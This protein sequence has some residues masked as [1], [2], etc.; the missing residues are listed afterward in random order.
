MAA[1][2]S[3]EQAPPLD[4]TFRFFLTAPWFGAAA[5]LLLAWS[6]PAALASRWLPQAMAL[7][8]LL[9]AGFLLQ[10]MCG[11]LM[12]VV[13]V[14]AGANIARPRLVATVVHGA[15]TLGAAALTV[16]FLAG[17]ADWMAFAQIALGAGITVFV[18]AVVAAL[19]NAAASPM[20]P[21]LR[22]ALAALAVTALLG[23][24]L[25]QALSGRPGLPPGLSF[26]GVVDVHAS[27]GLGAWA[28]VLL[29]GVSFVVVPMF[30]LTPPYPAWLQRA[31]A[32]GLLGLLAL[33]AVAVLCGAG[34]AARALGAA[35]LLL[36]AVFALATLHLQ[37]RSR[38][39]R[40]DATRLFFRAAMASLLAAVALL[41]APAAGLRSLAGPGAEVA[42]G[43]LLLC[44]VLVSAVCG[45]LYKIVPFICWLKRP[46]GPARPGRESLIT[47]PAMRMQARLHFVSLALL[48]AS[49]AFP[50]A[51]RAAGLAFAASCALLGA[52]LVRATARALRA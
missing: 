10:A 11:A 50:A 52:N 7:V 47:E 28:L 14:M 3:F 34:L 21:A 12:Q 30:Q 16:A 27:A 23:I 35:A 29:A 41:L 38:R 40:A 33:R 49:P 31:F 22:I 20:R 6:G 18:G 5:G 48:L 8:H 46:A 17:R 24:G 9:A 45:M 42:A 36:C 15:L 2:L 51:A 39:A 26:V 25:A 1:T 13:P 32:P 4:A 37:R 43:V 44:G 19:P